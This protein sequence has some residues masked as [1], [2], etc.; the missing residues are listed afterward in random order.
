MSIYGAANGRVH[1]KDGNSVDCIRFGRGPR[2]IVVLPGLGDGLKTVEGMALPMSIMYR[3]LTRDYTVYMFSRRRELP[4]H[5][6]TRQMARDVAH[7][8]HVLRISDAYVLGV[9]Q[10]GMIA[11]W[12]AIDYPQM[13]QKLILAVTMCRAN[14]VVRQVIELWIRLAERRDY[15]SIIEDTAK[16]SYTEKRLRITRWMYTLL[17]KIGGV[18]DFGRFLT[19][20]ESCLR[21]DASKEIAK[22]QCPVLIIGGRR[23][24]IVSDKASEEIH[25]RIPGSSL[26]MYD[27]LGHGLYEEADDFLERVTSFFD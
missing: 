3:K 12:L 2:T 1:F 14:P 24:K 10:G 11:Q 8:M 15:S 4:R 23:D 9:S 7:A 22:I 17:G 18:E 13:V 25:E 26:Y 6:T 19:L 27:D 20:A 5:F 16:R 21:H